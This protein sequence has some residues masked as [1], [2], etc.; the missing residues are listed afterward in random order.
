MN[1]GE[2]IKFVRRAQG[3]SQS[4]LAEKIGVLKQTIYRYERGETKGIPSDMLEKIAK[5]LDVSPLYLMGWDNNLSPSKNVYKE[6]TNILIP[7]YGSV[8]AGVPV[9]A[10]EDIRGEMDIP[11]FKLTG[12]REYIGL[13]V[14]GYSMYP[15]YMPGDLILVELTP[16]FTSGQDVVVYV[17]GYDAT[18]KTIYKNRDGSITLKPVNPEYPEMT[19]RPEGGQKIQVLG[20]VREMRR[21]I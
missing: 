11:Y 13:E 8:P 6:Q 21:N 10:I 4:E 7:V 17:D 12:S 20:I 15:K 2:R 3:M 14:S 19:Y 9:E 18:L 1:I 16:D 5:A